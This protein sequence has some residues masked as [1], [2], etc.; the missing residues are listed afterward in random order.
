MKKITLLAFLFVF[1]IIAVS[2]QAVIDNPKT[3]LSLNN[4]CTIK[5]VEITDSTTVLHV[6]TKC[7]PGWWINIPK[8]TYIQPNEGEKLHVKRAEGISLSEQYA[9]PASGEV[10]YTLV[11][12]AIPKGTAFIDY[13]EGNDGGSWFIYD[14]Q[15]KPVKT[16]NALPKELIGNWFDKTTGSWVFGI[17][18]N[19]IV[20]KNK[21][22]TYT[23]PKAK[24]NVGSILINNDGKVLELFYKTLSTGAALLG[25]SVQALKEYGDNAEEARKVKPADDKPYELPVF[26]VDSATYSGYIKNYTIRTG[27]KTFSISIDDIITGK[28]SK[29]IIRIDQNGYFSTK[30]P[31]Y[32]PHVCWVRSPIF[33]GSVFLEPGK[34]LFQLLNPSHAMLFM[35]ETAKINADKIFEAIIEKYKGKVIYIDFWAHGAALV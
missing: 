28:Q 12:P 17:Y 33:N 27:L 19:H 20:Y 23:L 15:I 16:I 35:G 18:E 22:W 5:K 25:E 30:L 1:H 21:L 14:I 9:M 7:P 34:D 26:K 6:K 24:K 13:D 31:L 29:F 4:N 3:G 10:D 11:F 8:E 2:A 32:Y